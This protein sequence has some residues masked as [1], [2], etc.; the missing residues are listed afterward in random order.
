MA[1]VIVRR[2]AHQP[3]SDIHRLVLASFQKLLDRKG[4]SAVRVAEL[5][6]ATKKDP[7]TVKHHLELFAAVGSIVFLDAAHTLAS[8]PSKLQAAASQAEGRAWVTA[9]YGPLVAAWASEAEDVWNNV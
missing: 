4:E 9:A 2:Q 7:R 6:R 8:V 1:S 5:A 3:A